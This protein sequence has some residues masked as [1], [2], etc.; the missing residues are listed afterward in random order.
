MA[1]APDALHQEV[2]A[3]YTDMIYAETAK[4]VQTRRTA[5]LRKW[6]LKCPDVATSLD[7]LFALLRPPPS[8]WKSALEREPRC[9]CP[10]LTSPPK[11]PD[12][13]PAGD[14]PLSQFPHKSRRHHAGP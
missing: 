14:T 4:E 9:S 5:F 10:P 3:D 8:Q 1:H 11:P 12:Y 2:T 7:K 6:R 13:Q